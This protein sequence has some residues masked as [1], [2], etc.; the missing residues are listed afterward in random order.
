MASP[1]ASDPRWPHSSNSGDEPFPIVTM[2]QRDR[3]DIVHVSGNRRYAYQTRDRLRAAAGR[4]AAA[5]AG[6]LGAW[7]DSRGDW[8]P[9]P[10][11]TSLVSGRIVP[12]RDAITS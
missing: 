9:P 10:Q 2:H 8:I 11:V 3:S 1:G 5:G 6:A 7:L 4:R 12:P